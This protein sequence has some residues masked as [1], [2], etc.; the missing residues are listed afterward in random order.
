MAQESAWVIAQVLSAPAP[1]N[2][3]MQQGGPGQEGA[4]EL[5]STPALL[6]SWV[7]MWLFGPSWGFYISCVS[8]AKSSLCVW[9]KGL[10]AFDSS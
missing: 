8:G 4:T 3:S 7:Q 6:H 1:G 9:E 5:E 2:G 10:K